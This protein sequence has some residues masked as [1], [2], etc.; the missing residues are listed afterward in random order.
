MQNHKR[1]IGQVDTKQLSRRERRQVETRERIFRA[2]LRLFTQRGFSN[3]AV[4]D[5]TQA[6]DVG[7]GTFFNYFPTK[8]HLLLAIGEMQLDKFRAAM[9]EALQDLHPMRKAFQGSL[10]A[11]LEELGQSEAL[12]RGAMAVHFTNE[13]ARQHSQERFALARQRLGRLL[14][15]AQRRREVR[16]DL[17][18]EKLARLLQ[19]SLFGG[20]V[21]WSLDPGRP[22]ADIQNEVLEIIWST[23]EI[24]GQSPQRKRSHRGV[25]NP[26]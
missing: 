6:A 5:I 19:Q 20:L 22:L 2:G 15:L 9:E 3:T 25:R 12:V 13:I 17:P 24:G 16:L 21:L 10:R 18:P 23:I 14:A 1:A 11:L 4:E 7:K 8:D 26:R